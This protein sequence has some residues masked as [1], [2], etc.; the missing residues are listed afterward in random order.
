MPRAGSF[1]NTS[2]ISKGDYP[3]SKQAAWPDRWPRQ[4]DDQLMKAEWHDENLVDDGNLEERADNGH[5]AQCVDHRGKK[6]TE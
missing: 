6:A 3:G 5:V 1:Y 2:S 4:S